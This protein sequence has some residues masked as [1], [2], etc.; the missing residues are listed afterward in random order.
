MTPDIDVLIPTAG[1][2]FHNCMFQIN[3]VLSSNVDARVHVMT[4]KPWPEM[5]NVFDLDDRVIF[6]ENTPEG[7]AN[8]GD[9]Y[10]P[11]GFLGL[12]KV[13]WALDHIELAD[14]F[15]YFHDDDALLPWGL[16]YLMDAREDV[17][18]V[19]GRALGVSRSQHLDF[20]PYVVGKTIDRCRVGNACAIY[21][22]ESLQSLPRPWFFPEY[23]YADWE[24]INRMARHF[25][26]RTIPN[27]VQVLSLYEREHLPTDIQQRV[28][29]QNAPQ[30]SRDLVREASAF[31]VPRC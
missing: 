19:V 7:G 13:S 2:R 5:R 12:P 10:N 3:A 29:E 6:Y 31:G 24:L 14:W 20:T 27:T 17:S 25:P 21:E 26:Y 15:C 4:S 18:M 8:N 28:D 11:S 16:K 9:V 1:K 30:E 22:T 23:I